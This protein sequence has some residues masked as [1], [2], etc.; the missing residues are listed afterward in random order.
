MTKNQRSDSMAMHYARQFRCSVPAATD[1]LRYRSRS[2]SLS[3]PLPPLVASQ[4]ATPQHVD[5]DTQQNHYPCDTATL[6]TGPSGGMP[7]YMSTSVMQALQSQPKFTYQS[8]VVDSRD[9]CA[10]YKPKNVKRPINEIE[11]PAK[12]SIVESGHFIT[13]PTLLKDIPPSVTEQSSG[14]ETDKCHGEPGRSDSLH[15][16]QTLVVP[17]LMFAFKTRELTRGK[18]FAKIVRPMT[19]VTAAMARRN[20]GAMSKYLNAHCG[21][22]SFGRRLIIHKP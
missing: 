6:L 16:Q 22:A 19:N 12:Y 17:R 5:L 2:T 18:R 15:C 9:Y 11:R 20:I 7:A 1:P 8:H 10:R 21:K 3:R 13:P 14:M 4:I